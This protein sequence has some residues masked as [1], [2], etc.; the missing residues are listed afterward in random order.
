MNEKTTHPAWVLVHKR[1]GTE[2]KL[3]NGRYYLY[4]VKSQYDKVLKRSKKISLGILGRI[5]EKE[6]F[7]ASDKKEL[8]LKSAKTYHNK[9]IFSLEYG[10][11]KWLFSRM[12]IDGILG[13]LKQHFPNLWQLIV[14]MVYC[15][16]AYQSPLKNIYFHLQQ[17]DLLNLLGWKGEIYDQKISDSLFELGSMQESI[18]AFMQPKNKEKRTVLIDATDIILQSKNITLSQKGYNAKMDF[19]PQF[20]L[21]YLYDAVSLQGFWR[22]IFEKFLL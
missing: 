9:E 7:V 17:S 1:Q 15:R 2:I 4:A 16:I 10:F 19:Q 12:E 20:V 11:S 8:N 18:H 21:L 3:I 13:D 6:G 5:Y 14:M 22:A